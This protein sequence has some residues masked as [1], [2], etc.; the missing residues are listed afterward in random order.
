MLQEIISRDDAA[1]RGLKRYYTGKPCARRGHLSERFVVNGGCIMCMQRKSPTQA[2]LA[3]NVGWPY[4]GLVFTVPDVTQDEKEAAFRYIEA[5]HWH[6][7]AVLELRKD[8][9]LL[10][11]YRTPVPPTEVARLQAALERAQ[12]Q[13]PSQDALLTL[14][15]GFGQLHYGAPKVVGDLV[16]CN[17]CRKVQRVVKVE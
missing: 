17:D 13:G 4:A 2:V 16:S 7:H 8:P 5:M 6:D 1:S 15:C 12:A 11:R 14:A 3:P 9:Q 10:Q